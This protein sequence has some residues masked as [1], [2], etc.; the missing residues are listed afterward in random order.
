MKQ[1]QNVKG[2]RMNRC[3]RLYACSCF[4]RSWNRLVFQIDLINVLEKLP[5]WKNCSIK[6]IYIKQLNGNLSE[7]LLN[8][9]TKDYLNSIDVS[10]IEKIISA[11][12]INV[13]FKNF[14]DCSEYSINIVSSRNFKVNCS[15]NKP[16]IIVT[17]LN[18]GNYFDLVGYSSTKAL[19]YNSGRI[20]HQLRACQLRRFQWQR[21]ARPR[22]HY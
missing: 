11:F 14:F 2:F 20:R 6:T 7:S 4:S 1:L 3:R 16:S 5:H 17:S 18:N 15:D 8:N 12:I 22:A 9:D 13:E 10:S 19:T 21:P